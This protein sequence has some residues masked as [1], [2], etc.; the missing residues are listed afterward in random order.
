MLQVIVVSYNSAAALPRCLESVVSA[1][2]GIR[3]RIAVVDNASRDDSV[4]AVRALFPRV[5]VLPQERNLGFAAAN[6]V[7]LERCGE[8]YVLAVN[9]DA[10]LH[11]GAVG[12]LLAALE[13]Q[14]NVALAGPAIVYEDG[15]PQVSFGPFPSLLGDLAQRRLALACKSR[16]P[17]VKA[18]LRRRLRAPF[19]PDWISGACF[20]ARTRDLERVGFFDPDFFLYLEDVDLCHRL[21]RTGQRVMVEPEARCSHIE[22][23]SHENETSMRKHYRRSRLLYENKHGGRLGFHLYKLLRARD[24]PLSYDPSKRLGGDR[25]RGGAL[26]TKAR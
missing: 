9:P 2:E 13:A 22:G 21:R 17:G 15:F 11:D 23:A 26:R 5:E 7:V 25:G 20:L 19:F 10:V 8:P 14:D 16:K 18:K 24:I 3:T 1:C 12:I 4:A 6:N